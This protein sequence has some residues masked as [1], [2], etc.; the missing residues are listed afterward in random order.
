M[1]ETKERWKER[2]ANAPKG[3][4]IF[5]AVIAG[6]FFAALFAF[7]F[8]IVIQALW[9]WLMPDLFHLAQITYWQ[10]FGIA[11]LT[12]LL[13]GSFRGSSS[14]KDKAEE[15]KKKKGAVRETVEEAIKEECRPKNW[16]Y[17]DEWWEK[18]G[19]TAFDAYT[20]KQNPDKPNL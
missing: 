20:D 15:K 4:K 3:R 17:Y 6:I 8:A 19:K 16:K 12:R 9:N 10:A 13:F 11:L 14:S 2:W 18:E 5:T 7:V 1:D